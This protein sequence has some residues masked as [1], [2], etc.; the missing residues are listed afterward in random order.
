[1]A[2]YVYECLDESGRRQK[3]CI[4]ACDRIEAAARLRDKQLTVTSLHRES[5]L[6]RLWDRRP[7]QGHDRFRI[8]FCHQMHIML[9]AGV[10]VLEAVRIFAG[11]LDK[12]H[13]KSMERLL[14]HLVDGYSL[15]ESMCFMEKEFSRTMVVMVQGGE[16]SGNLAEIL[17]RLYQIFRK[18]QET[19]QKLELAMA[20]PCLLCIIGAVLV[21]F[22][23]CQ[24]LPV[25]AEVFA[26]FG[27][28]LPGTT[29]LLLALSDNFS[30]WAAVMATG[31]LLFFALGLAGE[32]INWLGMKL[33]RFVLFLPVW[34]RLKLR[35]EQATFLSVLAMMAHSGIRLHQGIGIVRNMSRNMYWRFSCDSM[36]VQLEQG[37]SLGVCMEKSGMFP[38][39]VLSMIK[40]GEQSGE[41]ARMLECAGEACQDD[42]EL[43]MERIN[44]LAEPMVML[45]LGGVTGFIVFSTVL[46]I[47]DLMCVM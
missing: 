10:P 2:V 7:W 38:A 40:A 12:A 19:L 36:S 26:G 29:R 20:Y 16:L 41:L 15:S 9:G 14:Q 18:R 33:G 42:A 23:L 3:G 31:L 32:K 24:V 30:A 46:P 17:G 22:L 25:F 43:L 45:L 47:L 11:D 28:E 34:G 4:A 5:W 35:S 37:Y 8:A 39:M 13:K 6:K 44:V 1:M 21:V 27:A